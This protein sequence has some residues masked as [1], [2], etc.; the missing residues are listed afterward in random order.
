VRQGLRLLLEGQPDF[1]VIGEAAEDLE[2]VSLLKALQPNVLVLDLMTSD[3][4]GLE[5]TR[6]VQRSA[7]ATHMVILSSYSD[8]AHVL[9]ALRCG[10]LA[11]VLKG[12]SA[13]CLFRAV[14]EANAGRRYLRP[15]LSEWILDAYL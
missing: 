14:R 2:T 13:S 8:E 7:P 1:R 4:N 10:A 3:F 5:V 15:P 12:S 9:E 11:Y 6:Q